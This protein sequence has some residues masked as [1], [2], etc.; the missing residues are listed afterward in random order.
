MPSATALR[1]QIED[2]LAK[3]IPSALTPA[4][5]IIRPVSPSG[6]GPVDDLLEGGLPLGAI[7][8]ITGSES[9]GRTSFALSFIAQI[10][11]TE[12]VC[13]WIDL[14]DTLHPESAAAVGVELQRLLWVR[15]GVHP[16]RPTPLGLPL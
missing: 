9:S 16:L 3:R 1:N 6:I 2:T 12:K 11:K 5:R 10:T 14:S 13:A 8:E 4:P 7:T 15:C